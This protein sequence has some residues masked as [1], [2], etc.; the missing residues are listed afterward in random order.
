M[1]PLSAALNA[2]MSSGHLVKQFTE[3]PLQGLKVWSDK[4]P[5]KMD[6]LGLVTLLGADQVSTAIG[7]LQRRR[8]TGALPLLAAFILA[9]DRFTSIEP[10]FTLYNVTDG[11]TTTNMSGWFTRW[12]MCQYTND[13]TTVFEW[14]RRQAAPDTW[15]TRMIA[16][17][18]SCSLVMPL[19]ICTVLM[20]DWYGVANAGAIVVTIAARLYI[21]GQHR[22]ARD[23]SMMPEHG[24]DQKK[25]MVCIIM[26]SD[27]KMATIRTTKSALSGIV[28]SS[29]LPRLKFYHLVKQAA[30]IALGAHLLVLGM[31]TLVTQIYTVVLLV[32]STVAISLDY[33]TDTQHKDTTPRHDWQK[34]KIT[35]IPFND[36]W[37]V[38]KTDPPRR[39]HTAAHNW[40]DVDQHHV[41]WAR[42]G[43][44]GQEELKMIS[45]Q[46]FP[47]MDDNPSWWESYR[48]LRDEF[49]GEHRR[50]ADRSVQSA[51]EQ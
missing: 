3:L 27:G 34:D 50:N 11:I 31:C 37:D 2:A 13:A 20:G 18:I 35:T 46:L 45:W 10:G 21:L 38:L 33:S 15:R 32:S 4:V 16:M 40:E 47:D 6:A 19:I 8:Y 7:S 39:G 1:A 9:G 51:A 17:A 12:L 44:S 22:H 25:E 48:I 24:R 49:A 14:K 30:W 5:F 28:K 36:D 29:P 41:A 23:R 43:L 26:R 42:L